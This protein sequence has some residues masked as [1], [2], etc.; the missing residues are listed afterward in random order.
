MPES[1]EGV[2]VTRSRRNVDVDTP[3]GR[4]RCTLRGKFR[5]TSN[6]RALVVVGD[7]VLVSPGGGDEGVLEEVKPRRSE[8][9]RGT[10]AGVPVVIAANLDQL[11][12]VLA[13]SEPP[14][15]WSLVDRMLACAERDGLEAGICLNK[16]DQ[17]SDDVVEAARLQ[18][19]L[20]VYEG[21]GYPVFRIS[22]LAG[23]GLAN[24][25]E[26]LRNKSTAASGHSGVGKST[27]L[28][29]LDPSLKRRTGAVNQV[30]GKG[31]HTTSAVELLPM[32][33]GGYVADTPGFRTFSLLGL[34]PAELG[35]Q[36]PELRALLNTCK[37]PDCLHVREPQCAVRD[38][39]A[40]GVVTKFRYE[41]YLR[42]LKQL[43][44]EL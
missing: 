27:F 11:L 4:L 37:Y 30:T 15:R 13:A 21:L 19:L 43:E 14:P 3:G 23:E 10:G 5:V 34:L 18:E 26:W 28:N 42:I 39:L 20:A 25:V 29:A 17:V 32:P 8:L 44:E 16:W 6:Q 38:A 41:S 9:T 35:R 40:E 31:R 33:F 12:I 7:Q 22:A 2:V 1:V 36:F 24:V